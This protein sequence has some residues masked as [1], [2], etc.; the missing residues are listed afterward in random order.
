MKKVFKIFVITEGYH[1]SRVYYDTTPRQITDVTYDV[2][3]KHDYIS[4]A[5]AL[6]DID[7]C[8]EPRLQNANFLILPVYTKQ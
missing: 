4:E 2:A 6:K 3:E 8:K 7:A 1:G 5:E